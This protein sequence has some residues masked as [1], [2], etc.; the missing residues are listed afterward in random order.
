M[1]V[2]EAL[3]GRFLFQE[4]MVAVGTRISS[5]PMPTQTQNDLARCFYGAEIRS[6]S[7]PK[8]IQAAHRGIGA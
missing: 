5:S 2:E 3:I 4:Q 1:L 6:A 8:H 7:I